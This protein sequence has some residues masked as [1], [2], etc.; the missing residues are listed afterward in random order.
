MGNVCRM[1]LIYSGVEVSGETFWCTT[2]FYTGPPSKILFSIYSLVWGQGVPSVRTKVGV[3][4]FGVGFVT[5]LGI[6]SDLHGHLP[7][8]KFDRKVLH[9][10]N[11]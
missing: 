10:W 11:V 2:L 3:E 9:S 6:L 7:G 5:P 1:S 4:N 8:Y